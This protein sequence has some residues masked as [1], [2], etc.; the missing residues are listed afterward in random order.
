MNARE[1]KIFELTR[2]TVVGAIK[3]YIVNRA[4]ISANFQI[5]DLVIPTERKIRSLV[6][7]IETSLGT[8]LWEPLAKSL[9][10]LKRFRN[11]IR[12]FTSTY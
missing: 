12:G 6:G 9:G 5:L 8:T 7:G 11:S 3:K 1:I 2:A 4:N 10:S